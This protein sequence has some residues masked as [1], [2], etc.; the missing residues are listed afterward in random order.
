M[1]FDMPEAAALHMIDYF[2][3]V[4]PLVYGGMSAAPLPE[5]EIAAWQSNT[6]I[7]LSNW[8]ARTLR[9]M[10]KAYLLEMQAAKDPA[11]RPPF[12]QLQRNPNVDT[13]LDAFLD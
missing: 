8:E 12:G 11:R 10:S 1:P 6:G 3:E 7:E 2:T 5:T 4:G 13:Q 9:S